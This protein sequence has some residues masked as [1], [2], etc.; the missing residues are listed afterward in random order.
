[1]SA[2]INWNE[3]NTAR[4]VELVGGTQPVSQDR[5]TEIAVDL[6]TTSRSVG[7]KLRKM[8]YEVD[9]AAPKASA[10]TDSQ[11]GDITILVTANSGL[12]TYAEIAASFEGGAF[13]AKQV[14]GKLLSM[15]LF[16]HVRKA[17]KVK[18][19]R[20]YTEAEEAQFISIVEAG[21]S[22]ESLAEAFGKPLASVRGKA[23]SLLRGNEIV[24]MPKQETSNAKE[25]SDFLAGLDITSMTVADLVEATTDKTERGIKST[26]SRR[27]LTCADYDGA[28]KRAKLDEKTA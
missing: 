23:L 11:E 18:A 2:K 22:M 26:L 19:P 8:D 1:M 10:W 6:E 4:L 15:E 28:A 14:Q 16:S 17:E 7:A 5:L 27:G 13:N 9:K 3:V 24:A 12:L 25:T 21:G 20:T